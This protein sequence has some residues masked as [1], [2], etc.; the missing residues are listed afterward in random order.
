MSIS[1]SGLASGLD[2]SSWVESLT[3]LKKAKVSS[4]TEEQKAVRTAK[5]ALSN[6]R[7]FF[8]SFRSLLEKVTDTKFN[9]VNTDLFAQK[10]A[11][12]SN[13][14]IVSALAKAE[15]EEGK[16]D[17][18]VDK[19]AGNTKAT[20]KYGYT[21]TVITTTT[22]S[23]D[24]LLKNIGIKAGDIGVTV[25]GVEQ[26][27]SL[28]DT[29][30]LGSLANKLK[31]IGVNASFN[32]KSGVFTMNIGSESIRDIGNTGIIDGLHLTNVNRG[33]SSNVLEKEEVTTT[34]KQAD[35]STKL[36]DLGV[37]PGTITISTSDAEYDITIDEGDTLQDFLDALNTNGINAKLTD[38]TFTLEDAEITSDGTTDLMNAFGLSSEVT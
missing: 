21:T 1:F 37:K 9:V 28:T 24:S 15:A 25:N 16:Y 13:A 31:K 18:K 27:I 35:G 6:I 5:E 8:S 22:A 2:T 19:L 34:N 10:L 4:L 29:D 7:S 32:E 17:I 36:S 33:Y 30:T 12:S 20:S 14:A 23:Y 3:A 26:I 11:T 38:G